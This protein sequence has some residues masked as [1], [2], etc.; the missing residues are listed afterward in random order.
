MCYTVEGTQQI[1]YEE[2]LPL[3]MSFELR[4]GKCATP[5]GEERGLRH[6]KHPGARSVASLCLLSLCYCKKV[7]LAK[8]M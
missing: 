8:V 2:S 5:K 6:R 1:K 3:K 7:T 4:H